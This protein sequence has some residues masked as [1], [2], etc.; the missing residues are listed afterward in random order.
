VEELIKKLKSGYWENR[1]AAAEALGGLKDVRA[2]EPLIS[3]LK[4]DD[5]RV[6]KASALALGGLKDV[7]AVE[8]LISALKDKD[9][10]V[11]RTSALALGELNDER[12]VE[13]LI[14]VLKDNDWDVRRA[15]AEVLGKLKDLRAVEPLIFALKKDVISQVR[16]N[17]ARALGEIEDAR[18]VEPLILALKDSDEGLRLNAKEAL[19]KIK[20]SQISLVFSYPDVLCMKC[21]LRPLRKTAR[22]DVFNKFDYVVCR[23]CGSSSYLQEGV[24]KVVG[25]IGGEVSDYELR[26]GVLY[27]SLWF[28]EKKEGR[29]ADIDELLIIDTEGISYDYA[30]NVVIRTLKNDVDRK[31]NYLKNIP[32]IIEGNP[33]IPPGFMNLLQREFKEILRESGEVRNA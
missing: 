18:A 24:R 29:N 31:S 22:L 9:W 27:L 6:R 3:A 16:Y 32:V 4:D 25:M 26:D 33:P 2:V 19:D 14:A 20:D 21:F 17:A 5:W 1:R 12:A 7:R 10:R 23:R 13:P 8:P 15:A 30:I 28:E 11:R